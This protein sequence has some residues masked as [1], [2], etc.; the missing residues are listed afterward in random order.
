[1]FARF[2]CL[3]SALPCPPLP[4]YPRGRPT[5]YV[6]SFCKN[7]E[8]PLRCFRQARGGRNRRR[9]Y[10]RDPS[11]HSPVVGEQ[12]VAVEKRENVDPS[13]VISRTPG[14]IDGISRGTRVVQKR[15]AVEELELS[16]DLEERF[17]ALAELTRFPAAEGCTFQ[18]RLSV[19]LPRRLYSVGHA[20]EA[21]SVPAGL[22][23]YSSGSCLDLVG[24]FCSSLTA[25][26]PKKIS[27]LW[28]SL[29]SLF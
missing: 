25:P 14:A 23:Y 6:L 13:R 20:F 15:E 27:L 19:H 7:T 4:R 24:F 1:M 12:S 29:S 17:M 28:C 8:K 11:R 16:R 10:D 21:V 2:F 26:S 22:V 5:M 3:T 9:R 18:A